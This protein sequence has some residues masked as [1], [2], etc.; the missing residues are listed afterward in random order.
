MRALLIACCLAAF[1]SPTLAQD[2]HLQTNAAAELQ[3]IC[4]A[5]A[6]QLWRTSLCGPLIVVDLGTRQV[7]ATQR[8]D[9]NLL[10]LTPDGGWVGILPDGV[11]VANSTVEWAGVRWIMVLGP[12]PEDANQ[13]RALVMHEAWHRIQDS[14]GLPM[15]SANAPH[16]ETE[17]GRYL[18]RLELRAL[19]TAMLSNGRA[20]RDAAKDAVAFR[21]ARLEAFPD[22]ASSE[23]GL[24]RNE[25]LAAYTGVRLGAGDQGHLFAARTL[26]DADRHQAFA[27]AYAYA[28]GPAYGLLLDEYVADWRSSLAAWAPADLLVSP[29][30][31]RPL[32][33]RNLRRRAERYGGPQIAA[34]EQARAEARRQLIAGLHARFSGPR[35]ELPLRQTQIEF[36]PNRITPVEG[37][38]DVYQIITLRDAWGEFRANDGALISPDFTKLTAAQPDQ[39]GL[40]GPGWRLTLASGYRISAPDPTGVVRPEFAPSPPA[41]APDN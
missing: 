34:E 41:P 23:S 39:A 2:Y 15:Q 5:D 17:R 7:W 12:L 31:V 11:P 16:L 24:D 10:A 35:L 33:N 22:A 38:G 1:A 40:S 28:S 32:S 4:T 36:D 26:T 25:G 29:L 37:L 14:I 27:R 6:G 30:R 8:D 18:L 3:Q 9:Q 21:M 19:A 13:R 20:Q